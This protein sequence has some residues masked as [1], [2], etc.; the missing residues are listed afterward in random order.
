[1]FD[2]FVSNLIM[3]ERRAVQVSP[4]PNQPIIE[5]AAIVEPA[6]QVEPEKL[7]TLFDPLAKYNGE[8]GRNWT[9]AITMANER[10]MAV[11]LTVLGGETDVTAITKQDIKNVM[12]VVE[13][14]PKRFVQP[15]QSMTV[16]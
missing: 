11:L 15:Y 3:S 7:L 14:L 1:M 5:F 4:L 13:S 6:V 8:K 10:Y 2:A 9:K 12:E 16:Q